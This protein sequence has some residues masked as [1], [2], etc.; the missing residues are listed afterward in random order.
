VPSLPCPFTHR[1]RRAM[2]DLHGHPPLTHPAING[3][4]PRL[5]SSHSPLLLPSLLLLDQL[6][7]HILA[8]VAPI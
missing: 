7:S 4:L 3:P 5:I 6:I 2:L 1:R 8:G